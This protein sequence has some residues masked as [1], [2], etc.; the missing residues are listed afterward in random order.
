MTT[1]EAPK[2]GIVLEHKADGSFLRQASSFRNW[3]K[4]GGEFAPERDRYHLYVS[5]GC[6]WATRTLIMRKLKGLE[7]IIPFSVVSPR[8]GERGWLFA[9]EDPY[10]GVDTDPLNNASTLREIYEKVEPGYKGRVTVPV[11]WDKKLKTI[12]NNESSEIIRMFNSEFDELV[13]GRP[14]YYPLALKKE[15]DEVNEWIYE[16]INNGVYKAGFAASQEIYEVAVKEVFA[17]LDKVEAILK[18]KKYLTGDT[19][20][21]A[22]IRLFV[23]IIRFDVA[24]VGKFNCNIR[25]IRH[26][27][28][29]INRWLKELYHSSEY[30]AFRESTNFD[31]IKTGYYGIKLKG[32]D[33]KIVSLGPEF[34]IEPLTG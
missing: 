7:E 21:E 27:Y 26:G 34:D 30:P 16:S 2:A 5:Y 17:H 10:P 13:P 19:L 15:I 20:T 25:T 3:I 14:D 22:D 29:S 8:L 23:T 1:T 28:P 32:V 6:P 24:Y 33:V 9:S 11:L 18:S 4:K 12:V 31:H